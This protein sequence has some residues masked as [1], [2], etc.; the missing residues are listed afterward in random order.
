LSEKLK[1]EK[2]VMLLVSTRGN[3]RILTVKE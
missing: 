1:K 2:V 3:S